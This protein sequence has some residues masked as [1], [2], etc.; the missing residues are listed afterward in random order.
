MH[1]PFAHNPAD[2]RELVRL[3]K[4]RRRIPLSSRSSGS[5]KRFGLLARQLPHLPQ[6]AARRPDTPAVSVGAPSTSEVL[7]GQGW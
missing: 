4:A 7:A 3:A 6:R 1:T 5:Y 2:Q